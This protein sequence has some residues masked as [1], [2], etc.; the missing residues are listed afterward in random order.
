MVADNH[1]RLTLLHHVVHQMQ[2]FANARSAVHD[3]ADKDS[4]TFIVLVDAADFVIPHP[5][6]QTPQGD[7]TTVHITDQVVT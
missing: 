1:L 3:V 2:G 7:G 5:L 4:P 6:Q